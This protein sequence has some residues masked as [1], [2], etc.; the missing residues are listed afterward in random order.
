MNVMIGNIFCIESV[1]ADCT[2]PGE[3]GD[4]L[5]KSRVQCKS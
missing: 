2:N 1:S 4:F 5:Y 3:K